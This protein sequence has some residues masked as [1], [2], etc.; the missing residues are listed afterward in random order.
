MYI[1]I[2]IFSPTPFPN[3]V[4]QRHNPHLLSTSNFLH[5][6]SVLV[7]DDVHT[8]YLNSVA[9]TISDSRLIREEPQFHSDTLSPLLPMASNIDAPIYPLLTECPS[10]TKDLVPQNPR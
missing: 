2:Y 1:Y 4:E 6:N 10:G 3:L 8:T 9:L 5:D 7:K